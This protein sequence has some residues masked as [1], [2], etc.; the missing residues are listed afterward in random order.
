MYFART[1]TSTPDGVEPRILVTNDLADGWVDLR[2]WQRRMLRRRGA[3]DA[4][5][6]RLARALVPSSMSTALSAG[7][8]FL[9]VARGAS[10]D[11]EAERLA[12]PPLLAA[13]DPSAYRDFMAFEGHFSF[14]YKWQERPV[15]EVMYEFPVSY[16]G[17][18]LAFLG[19]NDDVPWPAFSQRL[20]YELELGIVI[21]KSGRNLTPETA[22]AYVAGYTILNDCSA[23]DIQLREMASG[24]GPC[25]GKHFASVVGPYLTTLD[26]L[27][28]NGLRMEARV[29]GE[30]WCV[31]TSSDMIWSVA[32]IVAWASQEEDL[33]PG[34]L[35][36]SGTCNGGSS[37][38][39]D[40][41]IRP[42]D[43]VELAIEGLGQTSNRYGVPRG[44]MWWPNH[45]MPAAT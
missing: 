13:L 25:K 33:V 22:M 36:G 43:V 40:R 6:L 24:L 8:A 15:P 16:F 38:E 14:G 10:G 45:K 31:A 42:G 28:A 3:T 39:L 5:A 34:M 44:E 29:N 27:P 1:A 11:V 30:S 32:E 20:D 26:S 9:D 21:G 19:P 4:G 35:L 2:A 37:I 41:T 23:R 17:N 7:D 18:Q 12:D